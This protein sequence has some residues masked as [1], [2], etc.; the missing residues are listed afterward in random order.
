MREVLTTALDSLGLLLIAAG[1]SALTY[2]WIGLACLAVAGV[3]ILVGSSL[4]SW[5]GRPVKKP[6]DVR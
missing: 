5:Q 6:G 2:R 1:L 3:V 4:A